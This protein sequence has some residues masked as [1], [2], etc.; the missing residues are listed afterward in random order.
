MKKIQIGDMIE[1]KAL[2]KKGKVINVI[3]DSYEIQIGK[4]FFIFNKTQIKPEE[5]LDSFL[6]SLI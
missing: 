5:G 6:R 3:G 1:V 4:A 2:N